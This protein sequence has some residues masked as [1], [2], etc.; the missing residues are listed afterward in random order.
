MASNA[1]N[2]Y[3]CR[4]RAGDVEYVAALIEGN[5]THVHITQKEKAAEN[6]KAAYIESYA[7]IVRIL[8]AAFHD[9]KLTAGDVVFY[10]HNLTFSR[11][12]LSYTGEDYS[13]PPVNYRS[14]VENVYSAM[15]NLGTNYDIR[16]VDFNRAAAYATEAAW[17]A[18]QAKNKPERA[19]DA[20]ADWD[21]TE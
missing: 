18:Q 15:E 17:K 21:I 8:A 11:W 7:W 20:F 4:K 12:L 19:V 5:Q 1:Y 3:V 9:G 2:V 14:L 16:V 13:K 10:T 6:P